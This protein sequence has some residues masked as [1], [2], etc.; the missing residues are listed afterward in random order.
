MGSRAPVLH[1]LYL[2]TPHAIRLGG[3]GC[4]RPI[5]PSSAT[6]LPLKVLFLGPYVPSGFLYLFWTSGHG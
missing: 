3:V 4:S 6:N 2:P 1:P 5:A